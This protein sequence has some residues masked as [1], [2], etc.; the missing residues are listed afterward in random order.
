[1]LKMGN[2]TILIVDDDAA[3]LNILERTLTAS[4]YSVL[5]AQNGKDGISV[6]RQR[7][8][9]LVLMDINM[10]EMSG[11]VAKETLKDDPITRDI[12]VI[13]STGLVT[14]KEAS[15]PGIGGNI[16]IAKPISSPELLRRIKEH[17]A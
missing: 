15:K 4:G 6:A 12:P 9:D 16:F 1:M 5:K 7:K 8:P 3:V 17:L 14:E 2:K 13:A 11:D 10:P